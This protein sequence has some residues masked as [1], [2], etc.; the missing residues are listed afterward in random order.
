MGMSSWKRALALGLVVL[1]VVFGVLLAAIQQYVWDGHSGGRLPYVP[2][3]WFDEYQDVYDRLGTRWGLSPYYFWGRFAF[4]IYLAGLVGAWALPRGESR[5]AGVGRRLLLVAFAVGFVGDVLAYWGG[6]GED[7]TTLTGIGFVLIETP[8]LLALTLAMPIYGVG[9][10]RDGVE[11]PWAA[12]FLIAGG[13][14]VLPVA[15]FGITYAPHGVLIT[16][17]TAIALAVGGSWLSDRR[18]A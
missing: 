14:L 9:L 1:G 3:S 16:V 11:S 8:A 7:L 2:D 4:L 13:V 10:A 5:L 12:W 18:T 6:T 15:L 17:L